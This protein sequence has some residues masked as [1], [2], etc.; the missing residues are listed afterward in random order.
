MQP[1]RAALL[2]PRLPSRFW[3]KVSPQRNGCWHWTG[4]IPEGGYG[5]FRVG[6]RNW[7]AHRW[8]YHVVVQPLTAKRGEPGHLQVDHQCHNQSKSC[9]A[10]ALCLHRR[11]VNPAHL[12]AVPSRVNILAG[13]TQAAANLAK[14]HCANGHEFIPGSYYVSKHG[15]RQ[16]RRCKIDGSRERRRG[17]AAVRGPIPHYQSK[18]STC[19]FGHPYA[20]DNLVMRQDGARGCRQC[21]A[22]RTRECR[23]RKL[24][25]PSR[26]VNG[27]KTHCIRDHP[28][29]G[30]NLY[31]GPDGKRQCRTC[32]RDKGKERYRAIR[33]AAKTI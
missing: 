22:R 7:P 17:I 1:M 8:I 4:F 15:Q 18:K 6:D 33:A 26:G 9:T 23:E 19:P 27:A 25:R 24:G 14:T 21:M 20:G 12:R 16:C 30:D 31:V 32:K 3:A 28:L 2:D 11:C 13:K 10:G 5:R 29:S